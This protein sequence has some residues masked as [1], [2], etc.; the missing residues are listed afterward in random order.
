MDRLFRQS[1]LYRGKWDDEHYSGGKTYGEGTVERAIAIT[2]DVY[3]P[4]A[5]RKE[6]SL[7]S[8]STRM[9]PTSRNDGTRR[10]S[11]GVD[12]SQDQPSSE[13]LA[14]VDVAIA[15]LVQENK[16]L[17]AQHEYLYEA[18]MAEQTKREKLEKRV[19]EL[20]DVIA[21]GRRSLAY[22]LLGY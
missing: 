4:A 17:E 5:C 20:E 6:K 22:R 21:T 16:H 19:T 11:D 7:D 12:R 10:G 14:S 18:V 15:E 3:E 9:R 2:S 8:G 13:D 1:G